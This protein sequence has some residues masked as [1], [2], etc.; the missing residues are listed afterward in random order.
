MND[1]A[2]GLLCALGVVVI[3]TGFQLFSRLSLSQSFSVWDLA[4]LRYMGAFL[5]ALPLA[6]WLGV[7]RLPPLRVLGLTL[8]AGLA[9]PSGP[10]PAFNSPPPRMAER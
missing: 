9:F 7:P 6:L 10:M 8:T 2:K 3:W 1:R 4:A 5:T